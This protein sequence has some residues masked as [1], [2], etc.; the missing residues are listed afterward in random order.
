MAGHVTVTC[1]ETLLSM[2][3]YKWWRASRLSQDLR[4][5]ER[6]VRTREEGVVVGADPTLSAGN[7]SL[8]GES[9]E[10]LAGVPEGAVEE[11]TALP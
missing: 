9:Q 1:R 2:V 8:G 5:L 10:A 3:F 6:V 7:P 11:E 4:M